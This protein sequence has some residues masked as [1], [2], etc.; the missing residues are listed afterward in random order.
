M[1]GPKTDT[2][3][4]RQ[5]ALRYVRAPL[6]KTQSTKPGVLTQFAGFSGQQLVFPQLP[7][8]LTCAGS[9]STFSAT[10]LR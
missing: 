8:G 6:Y 1:G 10:M 2:K 7:H 3:S 4:L 9:R 5:L